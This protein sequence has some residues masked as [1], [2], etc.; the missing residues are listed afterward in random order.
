MKRILI[1]ALAAASLTALA[2]PAFAQPGPG[3]GGRPGYERGPGYDRS[4]PGFDRGRDYYGGNINQREAQ[5]EARID[6][7]VRRGDLTRSEAVRLRS[8][9]RGIERLERR[10]RY[11]GGGIAAWERQDLE[12]RLDRLSRQVF[13][14]RRD[15]DRRGPGYG[16][17]GGR[18]R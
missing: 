14:A 13:R 7:G 6:M 5:I 1:T 8:E 17:Y 16:G 18:Y 15:E 10:Y 4:G 9:L 11:T 2:A 12:R 3:Y